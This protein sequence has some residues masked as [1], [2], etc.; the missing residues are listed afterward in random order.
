MPKAAR[1][2]A[3]EYF[4]PERCLYCLDKLNQF[5]DL[6]VG[7]N[8]TRRNAPK[9][10]SSSVLVRT[11]R[12]LVAKNEALFNIHPADMD[13]ICESQKLSGKVGNLCFQRFCQSPEL[14]RNDEFYLPENW[15]SWRTGYEDARREQ[16]LGEAADFE[17][18]KA[19]IR[20]KALEKKK[21]KSILYKFL[22]FWQR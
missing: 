4:T 11:T 14:I 13:E 8:Y 5:A 16:A 19:A 15:E 3:K 17:G 6:S 20:E 21:R 18:I 9:S 7:D 2:D 10:G 1:T 22:R 12:G